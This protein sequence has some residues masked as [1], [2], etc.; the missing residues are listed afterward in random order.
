MQ[1]ALDLAVNGLGSVRPNPVV[2]CVIVHNGR[3]IGEGWHRNY[4]GPHAEV[5]A[6]NSVSD[7]SLLAEATVY[8][9]L[10]PCA[11]YG[12][13]PPCADLLVEKNVKRVVICNEDPNPLV[14][15]GGITR[16]KEAGITVTSGVLADK[17]E[18]INRR[19]FTFMRRKR[20]YLILKWARTADGF[21]AR[22]DYSSK[23][24]SN[25]LSRKVVHKFRAEEHAIMVGRQTALY[26]DPKL[27]VRDWEKIS[28]DPVRILID[29]QMKLPGTR[30]GL[31]LFD[32]SVPTL[33]FHSSGQAPAIEGVDYVQVGHDTFLEDMMHA[34][35]QRS[36]QSVLVEGGTTLH[37][38]LIENNLWDEMRVFTGGSL[39]GKGLPAPKVAGERIATEKLREDTL[40][41]FINEQNTPE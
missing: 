33:L 31:R 19:F 4:G 34:L 27:D 25:S 6:V 10:E 7:P 2:G 29:R 22:E 16:M 32:G 28:S 37:D 11:H 8:V 38:L 20:P 40:E 3:I 35:H 41:I 30:P 24:I 14:N 26:D 12:K 5:N 15:G 18:W 17:G 1:R 36:I 23:W 9:T 13:T 39:F 21:T